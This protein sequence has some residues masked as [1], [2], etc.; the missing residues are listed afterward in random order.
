MIRNQSDDFESP[1][2]KHFKDY[3]RDHGIACV[4]EELSC[5]IYDLARQDPNLC[6]EL[7][8]IAQGI[9]NMRQLV[10]RSPD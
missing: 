5:A 9:Y 6:T 7:H 8:Y 1:I 2:E 4:L 10:T 3:I